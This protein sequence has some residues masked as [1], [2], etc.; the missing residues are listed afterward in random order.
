M[1]Q[2]RTVKTVERSFP[3][4]HGWLLIVGHASASPQDRPESALKRPKPTSDAGSIPAVGS[5]EDQPQSHH[6]AGIATPPAERANV[7]TC[8]AQRVGGLRLSAAC[9]PSQRAP[10]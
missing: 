8:H 7:R 4:R 5:G 9:R 6:S 1:R 10:G 3:I 2:C